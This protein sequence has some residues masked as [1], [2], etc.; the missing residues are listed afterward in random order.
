M[1]ESVAIVI[2]CYDCSGT[3][4]R[5]IDSVV[6]QSININEIIVVDDCSKDAH[7]ISDIC[8]EYKLVKYV[9]NQKNLGLAGA[10]NVGLWSAKSTVIS[11]LD[12]DDQYH[13]KK[14]E[15]QLNFLNNKCAVSTDFLSVQEGSIV[16]TKFKISDNPTT[17]IFSSPYQNLFFNKLVGSS[18][19]IHTKT[20]RDMGGYDENLRSVE[21]FDLWLRLL[22]NN[23]SICTVKIPLYLYYDN[24]NS[25]S[26]DTIAIWNNMSVV[27][28]KFMDYQ[29]IPRK[30]IIGSC[31]WAI[32]ISKECIKAEAS[33]NNK[34]KKIL[35]LSISE[36]ISFSI[37]RY[38][39][40]FLFR[41]NIFKAISFLFR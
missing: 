7:K 37:C 18:V 36:K 15:I 20:L 14:L 9:R 40:I 41:F 30:G 6:N 16:K 17:K 35:L 11:F 25:L 26:K 2:P 34:L 32:L 27:I 8:S 38:I 33:K 1:T 24:A 19:M 10:R 4:K 31:I 39:I 13:Q 5:A 28:S 12:A 22:S 3:L 21:D 29:H 23:I